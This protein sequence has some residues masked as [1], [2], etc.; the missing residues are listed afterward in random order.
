VHTHRGR[1]Q[2]RVFKEEGV[3]LERVIIGHSGDS[4]D[5][6]YLRELMDNGSFIGMDRFGV[7]VLLPFDDRVN[8]VVALCAQG[9]AEKMVLSHDASCFIDW[10]DP[11][12][13]RAVA[14]NW[15][16]THIS[17]DVVPALKQR[18]VTDQQV[19]TML[20]GNPR[21]IFENVGSY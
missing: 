1:D 18:G 6:D 3:D 10:F 9:Y 13:M 4:T 5:L 14:P 2:Q 8:T 20:V 17:D 7:D 21:R 12:M 15:H 19:E 16:F 11:E